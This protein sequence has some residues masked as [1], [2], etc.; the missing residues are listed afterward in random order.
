MV[1]EFTQSNSRSRLTTSNTYRCK[2]DRDL[3]LKGGRHAVPL[4]Q[5]STFQHTY[6]L[7]KPSHP[8]PEEAKPLCLGKTILLCAKVR[9]FLAWHKGF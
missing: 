5:V 7:P 9:A 1:A 8:L 3:S 6:K 2:R 4:Y